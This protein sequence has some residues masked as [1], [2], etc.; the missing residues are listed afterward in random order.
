MVLTV[1]QK[2]T[3][4]GMLSGLGV[5]LVVIVFGSIFNPFNF[6]KHWITMNVSGL[7][8]ALLLCFV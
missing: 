7:Q 6:G 8:S 2:G 5:A 1:E 4:L 3:L